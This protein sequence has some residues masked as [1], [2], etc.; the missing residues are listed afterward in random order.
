M[1]KIVIHRPGGYG[2]LRLEQHPDLSPDAN[3]V[4]IEVTAVGVNYADCVTRMGLYASAKYYVGYPITPGFEV[5]GRIAAIGKEVEG[6]QIGDTVLA[7]TRFNGYASQLVVPANQVFPLPPNLPVDIAAGVP[8]VFLTAWYAV[9]RMA[10]PEAGDAV[11]IHSAAG[12]VGGALVQLCKLAGCKVV[13]V[14]GTAHKVDTASSLGADAVIDKS[15]EALWPTAEKLSPDGY[16]AIFDANGV[17]TLRQSYE[18]L[19]PTGRL[20]VYGFHSMLPRGKGR[21]NWLA[22]AWHFLRT[23][24]FSPLRLTTENRSVMG[25]NLSFLFD[26]SGIFQQAMTQLLAWVADGRIRPLSTI[27]LPF[28]RADEAHRALESGQ[29]RGKIVLIIDTEQR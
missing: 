23:P 13:A 12:G 2:Q 15:R 27:T 8:A 4:M 20:V 5:S 3:E 26:K 17:S 1:H 7:V 22:L 29:S 24:R 16:L 25:F 19:A 14:V 21:P 9:F 6:L 11:L 10:R 28:S 18:H